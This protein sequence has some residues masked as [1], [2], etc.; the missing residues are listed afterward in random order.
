MKINIYKLLD[1]AKKASGDVTVIIDVLR[2][3]SVECFLAN[4]NAKQIIAVAGE[5]LAYKL[6]EEHKDYLLIGER[7][8]KMLPDFDYGNSPSQIENVDFTG[9]TCIH[10]TSAGTQGL[11]NAINSKTVL[12]GSLVNAKAIAE[13]IIKNNFKEVSLVALGLAAKTETTEDNLCAEY[14]KGLLEGNKP[15]I[16]KQIENVKQ[17]DGAKFFDPNK[18]DIFP[19]KD[20]ELCMDKNRFNFVLKVDKIENGKFY[21]KKIDQATKIVDRI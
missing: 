16:T 12:T 9:K 10:T 13:Y 4:N 7:G 15:D 17:T 14:I 1:G 21:I 20:F 8:G 3:F 19:K 6:K 2:A 11:A 18:Q 5:D